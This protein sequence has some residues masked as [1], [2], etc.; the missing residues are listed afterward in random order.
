MGRVSTDVA[1]AFDDTLAVASRVM[2][3][4]RVAF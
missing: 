1:L 2:V 4:G 3:T